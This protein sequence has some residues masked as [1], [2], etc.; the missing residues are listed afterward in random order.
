MKSGRG[1][2][3]KG[4]KGNA[5]LLKHRWVWTLK[6]DP[7][8]FGVHGFK[9]HHPSKPDVTI[10]LRDLSEHYPDFKQK[11]YV[12]GEEENTVIDLNKAGYTKLLATGEF[13]VKSKILVSK[14]TEKTIKKLSSNGIT[15]ETNG[16]NSQE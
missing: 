14:A 16:G 3:K 10:T 5:G 8:H 12:T 9:S 11:G 4:G 13:R 7:N 6:N 1:K 2:G 15:V